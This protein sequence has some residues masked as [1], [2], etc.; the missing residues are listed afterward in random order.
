MQKLCALGNRIHFRE[1]GRNFLEIAACN[2]SGE[3]HLQQALNSSLQC[4]YCMS[5][6][7]CSNW[8]HN[9]PSLIDRLPD[10]A[11]SGVS[12]RFCQER[13]YVPTAWKNR[14]SK[15]SY[16]CPADL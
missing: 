2:Y 8:K 1:L 16:C 5:S 3:K 13:R 12:L 11:L 4:A 7:V 15:I 9:C 6:P 10:S 14:D